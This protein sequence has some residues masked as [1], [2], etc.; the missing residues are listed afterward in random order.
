MKLNFKADFEFM[1][2]FPKLKKN[3]IQGLDV[4]ILY[5]NDQDFRIYI[6]LSVWNGLEVVHKEML[7]VFS[8]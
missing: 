6:Y 8:I 7:E 2:N 1:R 3:A 5:F 4:V